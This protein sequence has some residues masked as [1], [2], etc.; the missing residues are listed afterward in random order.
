MFDYLQF[1]K[2]FET[3]NRTKS[4]RSA[5]KEIEDEIDN[6]KNGITLKE[7]TIE[8]ILSTFDENI[9]LLKPIFESRL[10]ILN[11]FNVGN[12]LDYLTILHRTVTPVQQQKMYLKMIQRFF[13]DEQKYFE[14][15]TVR[16]LKPQNFIVSNDYFIYFSFC[17]VA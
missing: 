13:K 4:F 2:Q 9:P 6:R 7:M 17:F 16:E 3:R 15:L 10:N 5:I 11:R 14:K 12:G 8:W 1:K